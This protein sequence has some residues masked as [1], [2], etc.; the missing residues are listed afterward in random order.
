MARG[1][2]PKRE[3]KKLKKRKIDKQLTS[4]VESVFISEDVQIIGKKRKIKDQEV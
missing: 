1:S 2:F 4:P 3:S